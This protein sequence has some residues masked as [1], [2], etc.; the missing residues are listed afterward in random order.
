MQPIKKYT[1]HI[2][3]ITAF[4]PKHFEIPF[5]LP[6]ER[7][8]VIICTGREN[9][10]L[11]NYKGNKLDVVF[12]DVEDPRVPGSFECVHARAIIRFIKLLPE[13]VTDIYVC[14]SKG[15]SRSAAVAAWLLRMSGRNDDRVWLNP[16]YVPNILVY[17]VLCKEAGIPIT[18]DQ[19][20][21]KQKQNEEAYK[22]LQQG[23]PCEY[24]RWQILE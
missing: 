20:L 23:V 15:S 17:Y 1:I 11:K 7:N 24:E 8:A 3:A 10:F 21:F 2:L 18:P 16:Y 4:N 19:V 6:D 9:E 5:D 14:C 13:E 12:L 22:K